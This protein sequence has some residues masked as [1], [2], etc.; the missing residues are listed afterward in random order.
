MEHKKTMVKEYS[1]KQDFH[2]DEQ[3]LGREGWSV[4][5]TE[6]NG[7]EGGMFN[8]LLARFSRKPA[9]FVVTYTRKQ[10]S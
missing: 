3:Q 6:N 9:H 8:G 10:P 5:S 2:T 4:E 1:S 7:P